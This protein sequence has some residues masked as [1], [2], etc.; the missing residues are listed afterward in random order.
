MF[1][2]WKREVYVAGL[3]EHYS[4]HSTFSNQNDDDEYMVCSL[5]GGADGRRRI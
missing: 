1:E 3:S 4:T 5:V 2:N